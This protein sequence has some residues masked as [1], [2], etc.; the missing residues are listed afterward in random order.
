MGKGHCREVRKLRTSDMDGDRQDLRPLFLS[1]TC[2]EFGKIVDGLSEGTSLVDL[3]LADRLRVAWQVLPNAPSWREE[4]TRP[5][6]LETPRPRILYG[7]APG[8][9]RSV[10][11]CASSSSHMT[12]RDASIPPLEMVRLAVKVKEDVDPV[13]EVCLAVKVAAS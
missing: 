5:P 9:V 6:A 8:M 2:S 1:I 10:S 11:W 4:T 12:N 3:S 7:V 13:R